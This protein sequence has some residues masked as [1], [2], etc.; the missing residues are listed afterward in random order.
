MYGEWTVFPLRGRRPMGLEGTHFIFSTT[1]RS[2]LR[3]LIFVGLACRE[4]P[5]RVSHRRRQSHLW[6]R[7]CRVKGLKYWVI[8][9]WILFVRRTPDGEGSQALGPEML[10]L[11]PHQFVKIIPRS[12]LVRGQVVLLSS[13]PLRHLCFGAWNLFGICGL[14][15]GILPVASSWQRSHRQ[16]HPS[17]VGLGNHYAPSRHVASRKWLTDTSWIMAMKKTAKN[18]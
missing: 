18:E 12:L 9:Y 10:P 5:P 11:V 14:M 17:L 1:I 13:L 6:S 15:L 4:L 16:L 3:D 7:R 8:G 2:S